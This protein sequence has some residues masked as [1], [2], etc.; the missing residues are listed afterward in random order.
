MWERI[1]A[2]WRGLSGGT[3]AAFAV[4]G[5]VFVFLAAFVVWLAS[6]RKGDP[7]SVGSF[8]PQKRGDADIQVARESATIEHRKQEEIQTAQTVEQ[9]AHEQA[10]RQEKEAQGE[11]E[12]L[13]KNGTNK[14]RVDHLLRDDDLLN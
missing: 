14:E 13:Y 12:R 5:S 3:K 1:R 11:I 9:K 8:N 2:W 6:G 4:L 10:Q 7:P